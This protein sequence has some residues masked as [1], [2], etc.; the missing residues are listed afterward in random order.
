[1]ECAQSRTCV[2]VAA[3][4]TRLERT[5]NNCDDESIETRSFK[6]AGNATEA[7]L[8]HYITAAAAAADAAAAAAAAAGG[9]TSEFSGAAASSPDLIRD[10]DDDVVRRQT[11]ERTRV[12]YVARRNTSSPVRSPGPGRARQRRRRSRLRAAGGRR[13]R[14]GPAW[15][16]PPR[17]M[18]SFPVVV[19]GRGGYDVSLDSRPHVAA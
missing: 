7:R 15:A 8:S 5:R 9:G 18:P 12:V 13:A 17:D 6:A 19:S 11:N 10:G 4:P 1:M 2:H 16:G 3:T 14:P